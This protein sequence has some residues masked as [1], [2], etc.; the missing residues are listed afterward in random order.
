MNSELG[1]PPRSQDAYLIDKFIRQRQ[2]VVVAKEGGDFSKIQD[3]LNICTGGE[4][5]RIHPGVYN[6]SLVSTVDSVIIEGA[7]DGH[8]VIVR[9]ADNTVL[10]ITH[11]HIHI[12]RIGLE[13][14]A[15]T[16]QQDAVIVSGTARFKACRFVV[17]DAHAGPQSHILQASGTAK[18]REGSI[19]FTATGDAGG[20][21]LI[22]AFELVAGG[23][24]DIVSVTNFNISSTGTNFATSIVIP[25]A[26]GASRFEM[27]KCAATVT[28]AQGIIGGIAYT[29]TG[30]A[31]E[32]LFNNLHITATGLA[33]DAYGIYLAG[34]CSVRSVANHLH[35][36]ANGNA[37]SFV[38]AG[39][40]TLQSHFDD[41]IAANGAV[42]GGGAHTM[43]SSENDGELTTGPIFPALKSGANQAAAGA[44]AGEIYHN[45]TANHVDMGV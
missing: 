19:S 44:A 16:A 40:S 11:Q 9:Q 2:T 34:T 39:A 8:N 30:L 26:G 15:P 31:F 20:A 5:I 23:E 10:N 17:T 6:E 7:G 13:L 12:N 45:T 33:N 27:Y 42:Y 25:P 1:Y 41:I 38:M 36:V 22:S 4:T 29:T 32:L 28:G 14:T 37:R 18:I 3:A 35:V 24:I 43:V 21:S